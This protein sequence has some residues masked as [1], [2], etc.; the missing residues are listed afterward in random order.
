VEELTG[1]VVETGMDTFIFGPAEDP[2]RQVEV[3]AREVAPAVRAA[4]AAHRGS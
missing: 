3:F 2:V 4:V 1:L